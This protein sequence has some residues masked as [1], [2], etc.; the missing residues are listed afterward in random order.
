[1][2][3]TTSACTEI[4]RSRRSPRQFLPTAL[5]PADIRGVLED[6]QTAPSNSNTQPWSVHVVSGAARDALAKELLRAE[7]EGQ[8][9]PDFTDGYGDGLYLERSRALGAS[10]YR[11]RGVAR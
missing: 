9:S 7:E 3:G 8:T 4:A 2:P 10:V 6:A 5:S 11:T 1:M